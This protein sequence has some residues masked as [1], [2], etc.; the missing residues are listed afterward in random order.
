MIRILKHENT[1]YAIEILVPSLRIE[2]PILKVKFWVRRVFIDLRQWYYVWID[3][4]KMDWWGLWYEVEDAL[5][6]FGLEAVK[7]QKIPR[8]KTLIH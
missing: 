1:V 5:K 7:F 4:K 6:D 2:V 8:W 3:G